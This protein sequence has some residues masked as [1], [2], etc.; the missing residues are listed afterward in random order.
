MIL[1]QPL[2]RAGQALCLLMLFLMLPAAAQVRAE[3]DWTQ[4][5][6]VSNL[7]KVS[8]SGQ[9]DSYLLGTIHMGRQG[10]VLS[11]EAGQFVD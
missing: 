7:W 10:A 9:P 4:P 11:R 2:L 3:P 8:R 1:K 5:E 6:L